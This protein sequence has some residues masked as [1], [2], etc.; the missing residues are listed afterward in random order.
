MLRLAAT[1]ALYTGA[2]R[3]RW[4]R[5]CSDVYDIALKAKENGDDDED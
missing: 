4:L 3:E 5:Y 2:D 1:M